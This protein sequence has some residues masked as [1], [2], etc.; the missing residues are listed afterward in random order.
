MTRWSIADSEE[1]YNISNWGMG[2]FRVNEHGHLALT[3]PGKQPLD[4]DLKILVDDIVAQGIELPVLLRLT[5]LIRAR[6]DTLVSAFRHAMREYEYTGDFRGVYPIKVNQQRHIVEDVVRFSRPHHLGLEAGS[7]PELLVVLAL[8]DDPEAFI[9]CNGYKDRDYLEMALLAQKIGRRVILVVET[10][11]EVDLLVQLA[12]E[13]DLHP[14]IGIRAKLSRPGSGK[15][16]ASAGDSAKFGLNIREIMVVVDKLRAA[17]MLSA[18]QLLHFHIGSQVSAIRAFKT[19]LREGAR[20]FTELDRLGASMRYF[21]VGGGLAVDYDGSRTNFSSSMNYDV[22]EYALDV[23]ANIVE[24]CDEA[25]IPH[26]TIIT[27]AGRSTVAYSSAL[28]FRVTGTSELVPTSPG[29]EPDADADDLLHQFWEVCGEI[30]VK[31]L[32]GPYHDAVE[33]REEALTRFNLGLIDLETLAAAEEW[34]WRILDR[35]VRTMRGVKYI[36]EELEHLEKS[37]ADTYFCNFSVFQSA[38]DSWAIDQLFPV[39]PLHRLDEKPPRQAILA[40]IT[41][42][43]DGKVDRFIDRRDVKSALELHKPGDEPYYLGMFLLGAYQEILG[44]LHNLFGDTNAVHVSATTEA[45]GYAID[46]VVQGDTVTE[47][48]RYVQYERDH[49][50]RSLERAIAGAVTAHQL[51]EEEAHILLSNYQRGLERYTYLGTPSPKR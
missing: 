24:A 41:C 38:P 27:E 1:L 14:V 21:D 51:T 16:K 48:L 3:P 25:D 37:L 35:L 13:H 50:V 44:D 28:V 4:V 15:W 33:F 36:P 9:I 6:V 40:D 43:S 22:A 46:H 2:Y 23:V 18:L 34:Y 12:R 45:P 29:Q 47:V 7:K 10:L 39:V 31:N 49:L 26:P 42:D 20:I 32:Q 19:A 5:D 30:T 8:M 11:D 17:G